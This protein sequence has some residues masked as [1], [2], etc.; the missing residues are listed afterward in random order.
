MVLQQNTQVPIW[1]WADAGEKIVIK[2]SWVEGAITTIA[3]PQGEWIIKLISPPAGGPYKLVIT[4]YNTIELNNILS[5]EVWFASGQSNMAMALKNSEFGAKAIEQAKCPSIRLFYIKRISSP[6]Q[7]LDCE[8]LW[9]ESTPESAKDFSAVAYYYAVKLHQQ[10]KVPI[11]I[12]SG[13]KGGSPVESWMAEEVLKSD[14]DFSPIFEMWKK[15]EEEYP[16]ANGKYQKELVTW[17]KQQEEYPNRKFEKPKKPADVHKID[18]PHK[19]PSHNYNGMVSPIIPYA[20][21]GVIWYQGENNVYRPIQYRKLFQTMITSWRQEWADGEFPF[22]FV[23][24]A[25]NRYEED[26][27]K[28]PFLREAQMMALTLPNTGMVVISDVGNVEDIHPKNK[29]D[30]GDRLALWALAKTYNFK[31]IVY[32]GPFYKSMKIEGSAI[33]LSFNH[34]G[35]GLTSNGDTLTDFEI[36]GADRNFIKA[37]AYIDGSTIVVSIQT[38]KNPTAVRFGWSITST[39]NFFN[40]EGLPAAPFR[41]DNW[42]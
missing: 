2:A 28:P 37:K 17:Q 11:G 21:K 10:L 42:E 33:R 16:E 31:D 35:S 39:P 25:P 41:T 6:T 7:K 3:N 27:N 32:S 8:G 20:I 38:I 36:A 34:I 23:Q 12:I 14:P 19:R 4:G 5:G 18:R 30:V 29:K 9:K 1:G 40:K 22:Y 15:W 24:I 13:S 26:L